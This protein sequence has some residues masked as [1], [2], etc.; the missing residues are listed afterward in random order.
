MMKIR[1][2]LVV[3]FVFFISLAACSHHTVR[4]YSFSTGEYQLNYQRFT[5]SLSPVDESYIDNGLSLVFPVITGSL[6]AMPSDLIF[7][8]SSGENGRFTLQVPDDIDVFAQEFRDDGLDVQ[9]SDTRFVRMG[10]FHSYP[11]YHSLGDGGFV[12]GLNGNALVFV[13]LSNAVKITGDVKQ[14][15]ETFSHNI[16]VDKPGWYWLEI[17]KVSDRHYHISSFKKDF[18]HIYFAV[19]LDDM[20]RQQQSF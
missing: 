11:Y 10:T 9:P 12:N 20:A 6:F 13:Y 1:L 3:S 5:Y 7:Q 19:L 4:S 14:L 18:K 2:S 16:H 17:S 8:I 15:G